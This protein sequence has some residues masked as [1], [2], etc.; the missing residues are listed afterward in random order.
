M[1]P[2]GLLPDRPPPPRCAASNAAGALA[3]R[4]MSPPGS[5]TCGANARHGTGAWQ[6]RWAGVPTST[7]SVPTNK[8]RRTLSVG[9]R[10]CDEAAIRPRHRSPP[11]PR[12]TRCRAPRRG[13]TTVGRALPT[14]VAHCWATNSV[15][16]PR[17]KP[18]RYERQR[19]VGA[20]RPASP[21]ARRSARTPPL[22][23]ALMHPPPTLPGR[24][25]LFASLCFLMSVGSTC[26]RCSR[27]AVHPVAS[28]SS[29][30]MAR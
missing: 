16:S 21:G 25:R 26:R 18:T 9:R 4:A 2:R 14:S 3:T 22:A 6:N 27:S 29:V 1:L 8:R 5:P 23:S 24:L 13:D 20:P 30:P 15:T 17:S 19:P 12:S 7:V 10:N 28:S 11:R